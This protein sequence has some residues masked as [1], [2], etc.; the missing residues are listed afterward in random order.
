M[1]LDSR[2]QE[3]TKLLEE[4][5]SMERLA[6]SLG[7][8]FTAVRNYLKA[9]NLTTKAKHSNTKLLAE[10]VLSLNAKGN[11][12]REIS[13]IT[14]I[15][16]T[17]VGLMLKKAPK[18][19]KHAKTVEALNSGIKVI[20]SVN[21]RTREYQCSAGH[22][23][24]IA[25]NNFL[26]SPICPRCAPRSL[27]EDLFF[28]KLTKIAVFKRN[29]KIPGSNL[30]ID[31]YNEDFKLGVEF[32][33]EYWHSSK[34]K[35]KNYHR[36]KTHAA[37]AAGIRL[38]QFWSYEVASMEEILLSMLKAHLGID[39]VKVFARKLI[40]KE[41]PKEQEKLFFKTNHLQGHTASIKCFGL[42]LGE[43]L[44]SAISLRSKGNDLE[45]ARFATK[46]GYRVVGGFSKILA[47]VLKFGKRNKYKTLFTYAN[48]RYSN[49][50]VYAKS[51]MKYVGMT[52]P[53]FFWLKNGRVFNR[54]ASWGNK[55][56]KEAF[57]VHGTGHFKF[58]VSLE[59]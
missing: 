12:N 21:A 26:Q 16:E 50:G 27:E 23:F 3:V 10:T 5:L 24:I 51:G 43:A 38:F 29:Y 52:V 54:R 37:N 45:I 33:G 58:E 14:G 55:D 48:G 31:F 25:T 56:F 49:G 22:T 34:F 13:R 6:K 40:L 8:S 17:T 36:V 35:D 32:C 2:K 41:V 42:F 4:G 57:K 15:N 28:E 47:E 9:N 46:L 59:N 19:D 53:D 44:I 20:S 7:V 11:T 30:E 18:I 1:L 39:T